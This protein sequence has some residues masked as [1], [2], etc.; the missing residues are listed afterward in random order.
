MNKKLKK[1]VG[2]A[3]ALVTVMAA[4]VAWDVHT[5]QEVVWKN[6]TLGGHD[7]LLAPDLVIQH[8]DKP[9]GGQRLLPFRKLKEDRL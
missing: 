2:L 4:F 5:P 3:V 8:Q 1:L 6:S 9:K 7:V